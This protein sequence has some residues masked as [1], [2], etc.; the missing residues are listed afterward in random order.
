MENERYLIELSKC[1]RCGSCKAYCPTY[2]EGMTEVMGARGRLVLLR[3]LSSAQIKPSKTLID[4]IFSCILCGAC[5]GMCPLGIDIKE[6]IYHGRN[7]LK[8][9]DVSSR[10][11]R[12][13]IKLTVKSPY[14][15]FRFLKVGHLILPGRFKRKIIP[16]SIELPENPFRSK[17]Q[18]FKTPKK[19]GRIAIFTG[20]LVNFLYPHLAESLTN[21]LHQLYYEVIFPAGEVCCGIPLRSLGLEKEAKLLAK[22]NLNIF[23]NLNVE[24]ILSLCPTCTFALKVEYP[25]LIG[26]GIENIM[27]ISSFFIDKVSYLKPTSSTSES[28]EAF[29]FDPCHLKY[30]LGVIREPREILRS[31]GINLNKNKNGG[32]CGFGGIFSLIYKELSEAL[33]NNRINEIKMTNANIII[34]SCPGCI[35]QLTKNVENKSVL[36]LVEVIEE[37]VVS[38]IN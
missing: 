20:C 23:K 27:D 31:L 35:L 30:E 18:V 9:F 29:Y 15:S 2:D 13:L 38:D 22:R 26:E 33:L 6:V 3:A 5:S 12:L 32:C 21:V 37:A 4:C 14:L 24:A 25:K 7:L 8:R 36:H 1:V 19:R 28:I 16:F 11:L 17:S 34:T 10:L